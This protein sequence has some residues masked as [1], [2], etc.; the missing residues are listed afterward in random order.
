MSRVFIFLTITVGVFMLVYGASEQFSMAKQQKDTLT[1]AQQLVNQDTEPVNRTS[2]EDAAIAQAEKT[3]EVETEDGVMG[4]LEIPAIDAELPIVEGTTY[5]QLERGVGHFSKTGLPGEDRQVLIS[6]HRDTTFRKTGDLK[7]GDQVTVS[8]SSGDHTYEIKSFD[9]V[10]WDDR[11]VIDLTESGERLTLTT[12]Y[13]FSY[14]GD[15][16]ERYIINAERVN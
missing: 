3:P 7:I 13:P 8:L 14:I 10:D 1:T 12:C 9:I 2:P 15:A 11:T 5:E 4:V 6:G 16:P